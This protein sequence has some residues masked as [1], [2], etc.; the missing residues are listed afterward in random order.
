MAALLFMQAARGTLHGV[1]NAIDQVVDAED[2]GL[3]GDEQ[4]H[5]KF[6]TSG[7]IDSHN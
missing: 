6:F 7:Q 4:R 2:P 1:R 5:A 3:G